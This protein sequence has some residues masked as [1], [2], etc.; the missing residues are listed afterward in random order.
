MILVDKNTKVIVQ[1][2]TGK[3]GSTHTKRMLDYAKES[4][5]SEGAWEDILF[6]LLVSSEFSTNH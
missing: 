6:S 2:A 3:M 5:G 1:G 4:K